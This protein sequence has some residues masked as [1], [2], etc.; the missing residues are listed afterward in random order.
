MSAEPEKIDPA[1]YQK[2]IDRISSIF[3]DIVE[4]SDVQSTKRCPYRN[5]FD[6]CTAKFGCQ[7]QR[8]PKVK[9]ELLQCGGDDK[10]DYRSAWEAEQALE[11]SDL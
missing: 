6:Q 10:I 7:N 11:A 5:R 2:R 4:Q 1:E 8:R 9:V 3:S